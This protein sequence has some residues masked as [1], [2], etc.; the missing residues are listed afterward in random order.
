MSGDERWRQVRGLFDA[1]CD[2][3]PEQWRA[4]LERL[5][6]DP[7]L[8][9][10]TLELLGAQTCGLERARGPLDGLMQRIAAP[11]LQPGDTLGPWRLTGRL[12]SGGMGVVFAAERADELYEQKVAVKLL[13]GLP[14][15]RTAERLAEERRILA[16]LREKRVV[17]SEKGHG[18]GWQLT[19]DPEA[20]SLRDIY[21]A[22]GAP[23]LFAIGNR[24]ESPSCLVEQAVNATMNQTFRDAESLILSRFGE[25][26]LAD[27]ARDMNRHRIARADAR[28][29]RREIDVVSDEHRVAGGELDDEA[30]VTRAVVVVLQYF[31]HDALR[32]DLNVALPLGESTLDGSG[33]SGGLGALRLQ[34]PA[35]RVADGERQE[36]DEQLSHSERR[37]SLIAS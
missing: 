32:F 10:E 12:A 8:L 14:D 1:V 18:G 24:S 36:R 15:P 20:V 11:E 34:V 9:R 27:L 21:A 28:H 37:N 25:I 23:P 29:A 26:T 5:T 7:E 4:R 31:G 19:S 6:G 13:H 2:L 3:P 33:G 22:V 35:Q 30:L 17:T 16:G